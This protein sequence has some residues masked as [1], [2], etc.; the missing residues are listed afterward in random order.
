MSFGLAFQ[1]ADDLVDGDHGL[2]EGVDLKA[3]VLAWAKKA[4]AGIAG[5]AEGPHR[6]SLHDLVDYVITPAIP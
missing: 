1:M 5:L 3:Q 2:E 4:R 6:D